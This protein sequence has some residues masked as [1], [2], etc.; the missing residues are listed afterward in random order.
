MLQ[1][2]R[3][4]SNVRAVHYPSRDII[5]QL[6]PGADIPNL[7]PESLVRIIALRLWQA[8]ALTADPVFQFSDL[9]VFHVRLDPL[10]LPVII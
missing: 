6:F 2:M 5:A 3:G 9:L 8:H 1:T 4:L 10:R 7:P